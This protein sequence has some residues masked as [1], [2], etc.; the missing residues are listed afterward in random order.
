[1]KK[2]SIPKYDQN[3]SY[4][5]KSKKKKCL[6][7]ISFRLNYAFCWALTIKYAQ[8]KLLVGSKVQQKLML[9]V[10]EPNHNL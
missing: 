1:M 4:S 7:I 9:H 3:S 2:S 6:L 10:L 5:A 8:H